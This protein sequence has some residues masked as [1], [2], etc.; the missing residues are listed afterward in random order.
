MA[1]LVCIAAVIALGVAGGAT[2]AKTSGLRG[3]V[4]RGPVMPVCMVGKP[5]DEPA[6]NVKLVFLRNGKT[7]AIVRTGRDGRYRVA[8]AP[9]AYRVRAPGR[10]GI[11]SGIE[12]QTVRVPR[13][14]CARVNF[15]IDTG[16]R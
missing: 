11:G 10:P 12:P 3:I 2:A 16:I 6:A 14:R 7:V 15:S 1:R 5:C 13:G 4:M 9:G 8:L